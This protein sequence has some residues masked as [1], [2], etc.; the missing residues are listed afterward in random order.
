MMR[1][2]LIIGLVLCSVVLANA[3]DRNRLSMGEIS[4]FLG[5]KSAVLTVKMD[6]KDYIS[7]MQF[8]LVLPNG[9]SVA[10]DA[11]GNPIITTNSSR[12]TQ[13]HSVQGK[14]L[15]SG[16]YRVLCTSVSATPFVGS[17]GAV[18]Y[19]TLDVADDVEIGSYTAAMSN[20]V[21]SRLDAMYKPAGASTMITV[22]KR[23]RLTFVLDDETLKDDSVVVGSAIS[24]PKVDQREGY[25]FSGWGEVPS[26]MPDSD[27]VFTAK[28]TVNR[29]TVTYYLDDELFA[30]DTLE[31]GAT[32]VPPSVPEKKGYE[33]TGWEYVAA[34]MPAGNQVYDGYYE[35]IHV[36]G[37][38]NDDGKINTLDV[39]CIYNYILNGAQSGA[40]LKQ[41]DVNEDGVVNST[42]V[43]STYNII[44]GHDRR[45]NIEY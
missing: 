32:I 5:Q 21:L 33:F 3:A 13:T 2:I 12:F 41:A 24:A 22:Q 8:D 40:T 31:Y 42:D 44:I 1:R 25:T 4:V 34:T 6:N 37:D 39:V 11:D 43:V 30:V 23:V 17:T 29:Y 20:V 45:Q 10:T 38:V 27:L 26:V 9:F 15:A 16:A 36:P 18:F 7:D 35:W 19:I 14:Q 28:F